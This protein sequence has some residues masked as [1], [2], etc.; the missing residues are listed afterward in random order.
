MHTCKSLKK[1]QDMLSWTS[2]FQAPASQL[3]QGLWQVSDNI[4]PRYAGTLGTEAQ[5]GWP[6]SPPQPTHTEG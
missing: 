2:S 4:L 6:A 5:T 1:H 3:A